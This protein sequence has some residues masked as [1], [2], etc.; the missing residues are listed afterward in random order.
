MDFKT[1]FLM[2]TNFS[3]ELFEELNNLSNE[4]S[5]IKLEEW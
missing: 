4:I 5:E 1:I 3:E 2:E